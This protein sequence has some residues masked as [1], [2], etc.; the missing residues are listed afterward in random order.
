MVRSYIFAQRGYTKFFDLGTGPDGAKQVR[1]GDCDATPVAMTEWHGLWKENAEGLLEVNWNYTGDEA[2]ALKQPAAQF[3]K[4]PGTGGCYKTVGRGRGG[5]SADSW[6]V[7]MPLSDF[8]ALGGQGAALSE[9]RP[10][11]GGQGAALTEQRPALGSQGAALTEQRPVLRLV[12][13]AAAAAAAPP[14]TAA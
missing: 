14:R 12:G 3:Q 4:I 7:L 11:L 10:A 13:G 8:P 9:Q 6:G 5:P 1:V 2:K